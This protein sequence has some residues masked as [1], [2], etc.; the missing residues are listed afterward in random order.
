MARY[1]TV[2]EDY[3]FEEGDRFVQVY[4]ISIPSWI[5]SETVQ[6]F[7]ATLTAR[8]F[9]LQQRVNSNLPGG[10]EVEVLDRELNDEGGGQYSYVVTYRVESVDDSDPITPQGIWLVVYGVLGVL[11]VAGIAFALRET[12]LL[13][14]GEGGAKN[15][16]RLL[17]LGGAG[18]AAYSAVSSRSSDG[19]GP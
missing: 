12:R 19:N 13:V 16:A 8:T 15:V 1:R 18:Y 6:D 3:E 14:S 5:P 2:P 17:L 7:L 4:E 9:D 11:A 10:N